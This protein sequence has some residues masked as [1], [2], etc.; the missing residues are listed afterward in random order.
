LTHTS[1][2]H[3]LGCL[4]PRCLLRRTLDRDRRMGSRAAS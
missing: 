3:P 1:G 4:P 2:P